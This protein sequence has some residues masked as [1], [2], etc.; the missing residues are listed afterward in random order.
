MTPVMRPRTPVF[1]SNS[2]CEGVER[3]ILEVWKAM[4]LGE[5]Q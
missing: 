5:G 2:A 1:S 4:G 3:M